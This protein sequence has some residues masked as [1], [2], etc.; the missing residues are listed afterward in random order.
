M[1]G[2]FYKLPIIIYNRGLDMNAAKKKPIFVRLTPNE[3]KLLQMIKKELGIRHDT[4]AI[5]H[6]IKVAYEYYFPE[7]RPRE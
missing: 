3:Y 4:E 2:N 7:E 5:R 1:F 6:A